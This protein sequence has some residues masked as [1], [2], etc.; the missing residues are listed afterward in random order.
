[1]QP[2]M[3]PETSRGTGQD[4]SRESSPELAHETSRAPSRQ[5]SHG[6]PADLPAR[7]PK[8]VVLTGM[9]ASGK[10]ELAAAAE[11][12]GCLVKRMG[13]FI[14]EETERR[15]LEKTPQNVGG[16]ADGMRRE[17]GP[18]VWAQRTL[19]WLDREMKVHERRKKN[20]NDVG[21]EA[22]DRRELP[23]AVI[24]DGS[25][26][27]AELDRFRETLGAAL[28]VVAVHASPDTRFER[29]KARGRTDDSD[30]REVF[31]ARDRR[32]LEWGI[33]SLIALADVM[34]LNEGTLEE[35]RREIEKLLDSWL[36]Q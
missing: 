5:P 1:M 26:S 8:V 4:L 21:G 36:R 17:Y 20:I 35:L 9:P 30:L 22:R 27:L 10:G 24:I 15:G 3:P 6:P 7:I 34:L 18:A 25:R 16:T 28:R 2:A 29:M 19:D 23:P 14:W 33:G 11:K 32:E 13:D 31:D 12:R